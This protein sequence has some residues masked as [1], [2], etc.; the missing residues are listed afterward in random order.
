MLP[1]D[2]GSAVIIKEDKVA[3]IKRNR[4]DEEYYIFPGGGIEDGESPEQATIREALE[5]LGVHIEVIDY[6]GTVEFNGKQHYFLAKI[7][8]GIFGSGKG[9]EYEESRKR[10]QYEPMWIPIAKL[11]SLDV[12]P[13]EIVKNIYGRMEI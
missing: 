10:G 1:R 12:C 5:E 11:D 7:V 8:G 2:R 3:V 9:E 4:D 6:L 13:M